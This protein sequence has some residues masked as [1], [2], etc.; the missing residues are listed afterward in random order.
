MSEALVVGIVRQAIELAILVSLPMLL[1]GLVAGERVLPRQLLGA[2]L[3]LAGAVLIV[4][5]GQRV[6]VD[7]ADLPGYLAAL[8]AAIT[9]ATYSV[10]NRRHAAVPSSSIVGPCLLT[11][12]LGSLAHL[13]F[14]TTVR[15]DALQWAVVLG[16]GLGPVGA[17]FFLWDMG[18]KRGNLVMLGT[19]SYAAP[20]L[21]TAWL[22]L[23]GFS[24]PHWTH[25][26]AVALLLAGAALA[27]YQ[28]RTN[29]PL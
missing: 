16:M 26:A 11:A 22:L 18:T 9:W 1:A 20:L 19:L 3:G 8:G 4:T 15:P 27:V 23:A 13:A 21:S 6:A 17:A 2:L 12:V 29:A 24:Q 7:V 14:E 28:P 25:A 5:R 10:L